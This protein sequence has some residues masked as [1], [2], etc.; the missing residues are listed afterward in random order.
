MLID[1]RFP[2]RQTRTTGMFESFFIIFINNYKYILVEKFYFIAKK[3]LFLVKIR[4]FGD[5]FTDNHRRL[6][7]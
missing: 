1:Q 4:F 7:F 5:I 2:P 3:Y 6:C